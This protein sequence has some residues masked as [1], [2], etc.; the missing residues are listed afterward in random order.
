VKDVIGREEMRRGDVNQHE[1]DGAAAC[2][3]ISKF[4]NEELWEAGTKI[5]MK[6][7]MAIEQMM[8]KQDG[9]GTNT[10][11]EQDEQ[12]AR[13]TEERDGGSREHILR[14]TEEALENEEIRRQYADENGPEEEGELPKSMVEILP[15]KQLARYIG[16][17]RETVCTEEQRAQTQRAK[18]TGKEFNDIMESREA[19]VLEKWRVR[20]GWR[21]EEAWDNRRATKEDETERAL[22]HRYSEREPQRKQGTREHRWAGKEMRR[23]LDKAEYYEEY[24]Q[25]V[26][27]EGVWTGNVQEGREL[28][29]DVEE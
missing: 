11:E 27:A 22:R 15:A 4:T 20:A 26:E 18:V 19:Y 14:W 6:T 3:I 13:W 29:E 25:W 21:Q 17:D 7:L 16:L 12:R 2:G 10:R 23:E 5:A 1:E 24:R 9:K 8:D 28:M